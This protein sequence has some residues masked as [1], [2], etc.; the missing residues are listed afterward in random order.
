MDN[1]FMWVFVAIGAAF[2]V[3]YG[4]L[5]GSRR[6]PTPTR[7]RQRG[8][9]EQAEEDAIA[10][11]DADAAERLDDIA[12]AAA[13]PNVGHLARTIAAMINQRRKP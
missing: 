11:A 10:D 5:G 4:A 13:D 7:T 2:P 3:L 12:A 9:V 1:W 8:A 6:A